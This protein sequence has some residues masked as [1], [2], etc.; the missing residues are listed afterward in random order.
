[1]ITLVVGD[2]DTNKVVNTVQTLFNQPYKK[3][4]KQ[5]FRKEHILQT[6]KRNVEYTD[7]Q[8][9]YMMIGF[10]DAEISNKDVFALD[11]LAEILGGN[12]SSRLYKDIKDEYYLRDFEEENELND[13]AEVD[14][15]HFEIIK[16]A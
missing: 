2:V 5:N 12:N 10:R 8:S 7:A 1:M 4:I 11:V 14:I 15:I 16:I 13:D 6:Q 3:P 9:G